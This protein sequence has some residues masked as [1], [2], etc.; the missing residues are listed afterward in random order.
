MSCNFIFCLHNHQPVGNFDHILKWAF[1]DCYNKIIEI[2]KEYPGFR[3]AI[4]HSGPLLEWIKNNSPEYIFS[5]KEMAAKGQAEIIGG[6]FYEPIFSVISENDIRGQIA[7]M[8]NFCKKE[9]GIFPKGFWTAERVWDPA[10]PHLVSGFDLDYTILDDIHFRYAGIDEEEL[11][12]YFITERLEKK[13]NVFPIDRFLRYAIPFKQP[14]ETIDYFKEK[15]DRIGPAAFVYGDDGEKFGLWPDTYKWVFEERWLRNFIESILKESWIKTIHPSE[16]IA[17]NNPIG[18]VYLTQGSYFELSEWALPA[19]AASKLIKINNEIKHMNREKDFYPFL[20]GGV[21]N[22]FL[23][24]YPESNSINKRTLLLSKEI[25]GYEEETGAEC[26]DEIT[27][28]YKSECNCAYWHGLFGGIYL[29]HLRHALYEHILKAENIFLKR[30][31]IKGLNILEED[32]WNEGLKQILIRSKQQSVII[33]PY[34]GGTVSEIGLYEKSFNILNTLPR[35]NE[36]YH[37]TLSEFNEETENSA[38]KIIASIHD[39]I[40]VK[41]KNLKKYLVYDRS[42]RYSFKDLLMKEIPS[43]EN[44]MFGNH[45]YHDCSSFRY[46]HTIHPENNKTIVSLFRS[47]KFGN[48]N[49]YIRKNFIINDEKP[50][51]MAEYAVSGTGNNYFGVELNIN[52]LSAHDEERGYEIPGVPKEDSYLDMPGFT[53]KSASFSMY[54][55]YNKFKIV[56]SSSVE[57]ALLRYPIFSVSQSDSGFEKNYQGTSLMLVYDFTASG[58][59]EN[60][61]NIDVS[62]QQ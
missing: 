14:S 29:N 44:M 42:R 2:L 15:S 22:N 43:A 53:E 19:K 18:R 5:L 41:E 4:H 8:Q 20:K 32:F 34:M 11:F 59:K 47:I 1:N 39:R 17:S 23:I 46:E 45:T 35:R 30:K 24:K 26:W 7:L 12:G 25:S 52:L 9:F 37:K 36:A 6:G 33:I 50:G 49:I 55:K 54:D 48:E 40:K 57:A 31:N 13:L 58:K 3:F 56:I 21:W 27:E 61:F 51:L 28:L 62:I 16:Y 10:I 60:K 38:D